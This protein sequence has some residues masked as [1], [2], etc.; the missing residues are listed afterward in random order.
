MQS[1]ASGGS[2]VDR[3]IGAL[4]LDARTF[5]GIEHDTGATGQAAIV[6]ILAAIAGGIGTVGEEGGQGF[7][8]GIISSL[9]GWAVFAGFAYFVGTR[10]LAGPA[11][12]SSWSEVLRTLGFAYTPMILTVLGF[13]PILGAIISLIAF[14]WFLAAGV[15]A[16]RQALDMD[17]G[18]AV[19][20]GVVAWLLQIVVAII[21]SLFLG[22]ALFGVSSLF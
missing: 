2:L 9:I 11:T 21:I 15:I 10:L 17:T 5:E 20:V 16:L 8:A 19:M 1:T 22:A 3:M 7:F 18:R 13:I 14:I 12:Q 6:V 4:R